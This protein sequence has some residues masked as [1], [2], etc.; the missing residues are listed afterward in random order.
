MAERCE[1]GNEISPMRTGR[2]ARCAAEAAERTPLEIWESL[3]PAQRAAMQDLW[4]VP[5]GG[6]WIT[7]RGHAWM[8]RRDTNTMHALRARGLAIEL[9]SFEGHW[10]LTDAGRNAAAAGYGRAVAAAG[11]AGE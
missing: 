7:T 2:C 4:P 3:T 11:K 5:K 10:R 9:D 1:C 6:A 8:Q